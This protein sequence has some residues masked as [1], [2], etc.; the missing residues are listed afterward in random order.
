MLARRAMRFALTYPRLCLVLY[1]LLCWLPGFFT[2]PPSDRDESRFAQASK[3]MLET[4]D[5]V[6]IRNGEEDRNRKP[7]GIHWLQV[8]FAAAARAAGIARDNPVWPYRLPSLLGAVVGVLA[9]WE[10]GRRLAGRR[11]RAPSRAPCS[12]QTAPRPRAADAHGRPSA[13]RSSGRGAV[14]R[15]HGRQCFLATAPPNLAAAQ[16][17]AALRPA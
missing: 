13:P 8:P 15:T 3:Q 10:A 17:A 1:C 9:T 6:R 12:S 16:A 11:W 7:I 14:A 5:F 2:I 4:G